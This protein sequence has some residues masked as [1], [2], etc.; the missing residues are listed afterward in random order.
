MLGHPELCNAWY[1]E[2]GAG[3]LM[4]HQV[5]TRTLAKTEFYLGLAAR[6]PPGIGIEQFQ[7][8][9]QDLAELIVY[10]EIEKAPAARSRGRRASSTRYGVSSPGGPPQRRPQLVPAKV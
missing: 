8:I 5:V 7:H 2:T 1:S 10:V 9:Q 3:A 6:S 4:A